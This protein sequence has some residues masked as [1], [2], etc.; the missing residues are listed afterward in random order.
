MAPLSYPRG[1]STDESFMLDIHSFM[2]INKSPLTNINSAP[3]FRWRDGAEGDGLSPSPVPRD[4]ENGREERG[5]RQVAIEIRLDV[6]LAK[7]KMTLT[8]LAGRVGVSITNL[9]LLKTGKVKGIRFS[10]LEA[11][12]RELECQPGDLLEYV[13]DYV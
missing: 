10:T 4:G 9:S 7:R 2:F 8:E 1:E 12:C 13:P 11:I 6:M 5:D 3:I